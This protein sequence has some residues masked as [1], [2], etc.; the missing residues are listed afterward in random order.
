MRIINICFKV[1]NSDLAGIFSA[2]QIIDFSSEFASYLCFVKSMAVRA[3]MPR[4][5]NRSVDVT[6]GATQ[7]SSSSSSIAISPDSVCENLFLSDSMVSKRV[8]DSTRKDYTMTLDYITKYCSR[9]IP[10]SCDT[11]GVLILPMADTTLQAFLTD[12]AKPVDVNGC[13]KAFQTVDSYVS[14]IK[15]F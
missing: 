8:T 5:R 7:S 12:M 4:G 2:N 11:S 14:V 1:E 15:F 6:P 3:T 9:N 10:N 13:V